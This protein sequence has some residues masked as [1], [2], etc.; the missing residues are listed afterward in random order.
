MIKMNFSLSTGILLTWSEI[1]KPDNQNQKKFILLQRYDK[2][3][4]LHLIK[5]IG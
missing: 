1:Y 4:L 5:G 3:Q 2:V